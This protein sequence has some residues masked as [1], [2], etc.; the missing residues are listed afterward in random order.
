MAL[1]DCPNCSNRISDVAE[2]CPNCGFDK[3]ED[4]M[5]FI[6]GLSLSILGIIILLALLII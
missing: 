1:I 5:R 3:K 6:I 4:K 2:K